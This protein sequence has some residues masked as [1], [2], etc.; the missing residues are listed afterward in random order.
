MADQKMPVMGV[1]G[2]MGRGAKGNY[3]DIAVS[4]KGAV[5]VIDQILEWAIEGRMFRT[6]QGDAN[7]PVDFVETAYD[8]DQPQWALT[9]PTGRIVIPTSLVV[10]LETQ[11]GTLT[12]LAWSTTTNDIGTGT[13]TAATISPCRTDAPYG[14]ACTARSLYTGNATAATGL[15]EF[16]RFVDAFVQAAGQQNRFEWNIRT[17]GDIPVLV[18]PATLQMHLHATGTAP[19]GFGEYTWV[20]FE[21]SQLVD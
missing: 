2:Q 16:T 8:E 12:E 4:R 7:T 5:I 1:V 11:A 6:Q 21:T 13:S 10:T 9:V 15:I 20:E 18:G 14:S 17:A 3:M 19:T